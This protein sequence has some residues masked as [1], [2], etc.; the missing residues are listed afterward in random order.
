VSGFH[1]TER[2]RRH[3]HCRYIDPEDG[4]EVSNSPCVPPL[5][6]LI[7]CRRPCPVKVEAHSSPEYHTPRPSQEYHTHDPATVGAVKNIGSDSRMVACR[8]LSQWESL[9]PRGVP[10][11]IRMPPT[12]PVA[13]KVAAPR[14]SV[15]YECTRFQRF[16]CRM[17]NAGPK[18]ILDR[19]KETWQDPTGEDYDEDVLE[20][21]LWL[22]TGLQVQN[23]GEIRMM[24]KPNCDTGKTLELYGNLCKLRL[25]LSCMLCIV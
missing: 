25:R 7:P 21:Q 18:I 14:R 6:S 17:E 3:H 9:S 10:T 22:L 1:R 20:K 24:P 8:P 2:F 23:L 5:A 19:L 11:S 16:I 12:T 13:P 4:K 15:S